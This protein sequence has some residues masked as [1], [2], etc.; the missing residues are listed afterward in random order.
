MGRHSLLSHYRL[1][2]LAVA[3]LLAI[4]LPWL[5]EPLAKISLPIEDVKFHLRQRLGFAPQPPAETVIVAVDEH[6]VNQLG[7]WPWDRRTLGQLLQNLQTARL[8]G[9]DMVFSETSDAAHDQALAEAMTETGNVILG[10]FFRT[11]ASIAGTA[12]EL[13][14]LAECSYREVQLLESDTGVREFPFAES[15]LPLFN[16]SAAGCAFFNTEPD[17]DGLFRRYPL[18][19]LHRGHAFPSLAVQMQRFSLN[20]EAA[21]TLDRHGVANFALGDVQLQKNSFLRLN[22]YQNSPKLYIPA[23]D[24]LDGKIHPEFFRDRLVLVGVTEMGIYDLRP[25]P[26]GAITPGVLLHLVALG[27]LLQNNPL[28]DSPAGDLALAVLILLGITLA[29]RVRSLRRRLTLYLL[30]LLSVGGI[31]VFL[32]IVGHLWLHEVRTLLPAVGL[33]LTLE[34]IAFWSTEQIGRAHV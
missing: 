24:V 26:I 18:A 7:R 10:F 27:N 30:L 29:S 12:E 28:V 2:C 22:Y 21:I 3:L 5:D 13:S 31:A 33:L 20:R 9:L 14:Q 23:V 25:T 34:S 15:N 4:V 8:V 32:L 6:S 1:V 16:A 19:Y 11:D 17:A